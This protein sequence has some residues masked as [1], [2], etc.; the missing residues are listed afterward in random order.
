[1]RE[2]SVKILTSECVGLTARV[3]LRGTRSG[4]GAG[5]FDVGGRGEELVVGL[6]AFEGDIGD[7]VKGDADGGVVEGAESAADLNA[8]RAFR[9]WALFRSGRGA[10]RM[11]CTI[12]AI[13]PLLRPCVLHP[14]VVSRPPFRRPAAGGRV[15]GTDGAR[16][17]VLP[18]LFPAPAST[19]AVVLPLEARAFLPAD[20]VDLPCRGAAVRRPA[21]A[22]Q[23]SHA[24][25]PVSSPWECLTAGCASTPA[26]G[27][28]ARR[29]WARA[30]SPGAGPWECQPDDPDSAF[31]APAGPP[32][33]DSTAAA[34]RI[35]RREGA[36]PGADALRHLSDLR[37][38]RPDRGALV[39]RTAGASRREA[40]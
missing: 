34:A 3:C 35:D 14:V 33:F 2:R 40:P 29:V 1:M 9:R 22:L 6:T 15:G 23:A 11:T 16:D 27:P 18:F 24:S 38:A 39:R 21:A 4:G 10:N 20:R 26:A 17:R 31:P 28:A 37:A 32:V 8:S 19:A 25:D 7:A 30:S 36:D 5:V 13:V 12:I